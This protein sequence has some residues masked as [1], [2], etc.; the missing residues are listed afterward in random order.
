MATFVLVHGA[1]GG[2]WEWRK[3]ADLLLA[4]GH[5]PFTPTLT[6]LGERAHLA[7]PEVDLETHIADVVGVLS[8]ED[9]YD[10]I[11][12]GQSSGGGVVTGVADRLPDRL[13]RLVYVDALVPAGGQSA[14]DCFP[15]SV[16]EDSMLGPA[17][18]RGDGWLIPVIE[19]ELLGLPPDVSSWYYPRLVP[20]PLR[21]FTQPL[22]ITGDGG[23]SVP[24]SFVHCVR[25]GNDVVSE[26]INP[27]A[28][29]A[30]ASG[31]DY[32]RFEAAHDA[33]ISDPEGLAA[34]LEE[35]ALFD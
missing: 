8:F 28:E 20:Q 7:R 25:D 24:R 2:G 9:L 26:I 1:F 22:R 23:S 13:A 6:G 5:V 30:R 34:I 17:R 32:R 3:V 31:W 19:E 16:A 11:L 15:A 35:I 21:T 12:L 33:Q 27:F 14:I 4:R 18:E 10:V 29:R